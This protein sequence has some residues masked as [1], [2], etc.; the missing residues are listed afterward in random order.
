MQKHQVL[1]CSPYLEFCLRETKFLIYSDAVPWIALQVIR[2][3]LKSIICLTFNQWD[4]V[5]KGVMWHCQGAQ[6]TSLVGAFWK[7]CILEIRQLGNHTVEN[8]RGS[9]KPT[10]ISNS[11]WF[12]EL[13][14]F[15]SC[16]YYG[17]KRNLLTN[18]CN[19]RAHCKVGIKVSP[20]SKLNQRCV[21]VMATLSETREMLLLVY[22]G[23]IISDEEFLVLWESYH[24]RN[25]DLPHSP[26]ARFVLEDI[27][28]AECSAEFR[29]QKTI[30][31]PK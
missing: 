15:L 17:R 13:R 30:P 10:H 29:G 11:L 28:E 23:E 26:Y 7:C 9:S 12:L 8:N 1:D 4:S 24:S 5:N 16:W 31:C 20:K 19:M 2:I 22:D 21:F 3:I 14:I 25:P 27:N 18:F 6:C